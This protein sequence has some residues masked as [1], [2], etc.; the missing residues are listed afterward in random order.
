MKT[1][2]RRQS[3]SGE[4]LAE[5]VREL[6]E[7]HP[8]KVAI[9]ARRASAPN[10]ADIDNWAARELTDNLSEAELLRIPHHVRRKL[11]EVR[12]QPRPAHRPTTAPARAAEARAVVDRLNGVGISK[13]DALDLASVVMGVDRRSIERYLQ[14]ARQKVEKKP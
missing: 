13:A 12:A 14:D 5:K 10:L 3:R 4:R 9:R 1:R 8:L 6:P 11:A 7:T 2:R